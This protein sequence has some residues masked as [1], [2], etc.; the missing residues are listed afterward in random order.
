ML[1]DHAQHFLPSVLAGIGLS[2][3]EDRA[4]I[5]QVAELVE[6][7]QLAAALESGIDRQNALVMDR[8]LQQEIPQVLGEHAHRVRFGPVGQFAADFPL[9]AGQN[10]P[11]QRVAAQPRR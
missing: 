10:Q 9:Q 3:Q 5:E 8:G 7:R 4:V 11:I 2:H 6:R 1:P